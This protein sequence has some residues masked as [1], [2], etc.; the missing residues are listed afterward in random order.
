MTRQLKK[1]LSPSLTNSCERYLFFKFGTGG[2]TWVFAQGEDVL[3]YIPTSKRVS[4]L[5]VFSLF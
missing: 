2:Q 3:S 1:R 4:L 5:E